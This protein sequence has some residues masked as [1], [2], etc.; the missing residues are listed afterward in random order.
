MPREQRIYASQE[1]GAQK[2]LLN[3]FVIVPEE[4]DNKN[5]DVD[6]KSATAVL[7]LGEGT[8]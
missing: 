1:H 3:R 5:G 2:V 6:W 8:E 4:S 7:V